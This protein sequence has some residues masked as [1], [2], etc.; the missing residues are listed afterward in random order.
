[1]FYTQ[2]VDWS[3]SGSGGTAS[4]G[5]VAKLKDKLKPSGGWGLYD[6]LAVAEGRWK[7]ADRGLSEIAK[8]PAY[9]NG[10]YP[11][12]LESLET[13]PNDVMDLVVENGKVTLDPNNKGLPKMQP[14][15]DRAGKPVQSAKKYREKIDGTEGQLKDVSTELATAIKTDNDLTDEIGKPRGLRDLLAGEIFKVKQI[16][17]EIE[18]LE[19]PWYNTLVEKELVLKR[20]DLLE[21][22]KEQ[23]EKAKGLVNR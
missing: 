17:E 6:D 2:R 21:A 13:S 4:K 10:E 1:M 23:L 11:K 7:I 12:L 19:S 5:E 15:Q 14:A 22:R 20:R 9:Y 16:K 8:W 18:S 3:G